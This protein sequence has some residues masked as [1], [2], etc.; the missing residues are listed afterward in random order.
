MSVRCFAG[1]RRCVGTAR[2]AFQHTNEE[3][4]AKEGCGCEHRV[5]IK[6]IVQHNKT[7]SARSIQHSALS[8]E[9][10]ETKQK[11]GSLESMW[12]KL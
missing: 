7:S 3:R 2:N 1:K 10:L 9:A 12:K 11:H 5:G 6:N 8:T 4:T